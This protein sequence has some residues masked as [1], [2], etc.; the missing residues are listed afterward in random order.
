[1]GRAQQP[2][3]VHS[4]PVTST[5]NAPER[6]KGLHVLPLEHASL[7]L[8]PSSSLLGVSLLICYFY[9]VFL[10]LLKKILT[11]IQCN[12]L[13]GTQFSRFGGAGG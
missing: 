3:W 6:D 1:M 12:S 2:L 13:F 5:S 10:F 7:S 9:L 4:S 11:Y 8:P